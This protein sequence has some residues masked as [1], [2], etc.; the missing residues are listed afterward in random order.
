[1]KDHPMTAS[2]MPA[3]KFWHII[4]HAARSD[5]DA[6]EEALR[7]ALRALPLEEV[8]SFDPRTIAIARTIEGYGSPPRISSP[9]GPR[10]GYTVDRKLPRGRPTTDGTIHCP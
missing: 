3:D 4:E 5:P 9:D 1:M 7:G 10:E 8:I 6:H 2:P